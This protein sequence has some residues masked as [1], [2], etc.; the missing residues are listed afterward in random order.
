MDIRGRTIYE[1]REETVHRGAEAMV[2]RGK[3]T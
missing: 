1:D 3:S 2:C